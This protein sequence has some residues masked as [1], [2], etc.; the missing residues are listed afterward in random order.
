MIA[1]M[2]GTSE[3][4]VFNAVCP[5]NYWLKFEY[6]INQ[7]EKRRLSRPLLGFEFEEKF[8]SQ[9]PDDLEV[10]QF[11]VLPITNSKTTEI[12]HAC[13]ILEMR[14]TINFTTGR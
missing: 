13:M 12:K 5:K 14:I 7:D 11:S 3:Q 10:I 2:G 1:V 9:S 6:L 8:H 4:G